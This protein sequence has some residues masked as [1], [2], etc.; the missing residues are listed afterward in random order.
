MNNFIHEDQA[1]AFPPFSRVQAF[2][3]SSMDVTLDDQS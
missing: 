2:N 1:R 3:F